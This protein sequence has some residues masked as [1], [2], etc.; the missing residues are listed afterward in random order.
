MNARPRHS[1][2]EAILRQ[3]QEDR[4]L[5]R[6]ERRALKSV[7]EEKAF[8]SAQ[9]QN[10]VIQI[11]A[12]A[13]SDPRDREVLA[14]VAETLKAL[15]PRDEG[16][17]GTAPGKVWFTPEADGA[18]KIAELIRS[19]RESIDVCV[20]TITD[21][22][23]TRALIDAY[24]GGAGARGRRSG[25]S[26]TTTRQRTSAPTCGSWRAPGFASSATTPRRTCTTSSPSSTAAYSSRAATTGRGAPTP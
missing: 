8:D 17:A 12:E 16:E 23:I 14:W 24:Q 4:S 3:T 18:M 1:D 9:L 15:V 5:S 10:L 13:M 20:F 7:L 19:A 22:R 6:G 26:P 21:N 11:A 25:S 2:M